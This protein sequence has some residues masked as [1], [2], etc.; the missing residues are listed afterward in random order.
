M[1]IDARLLPADQVVETDIC[2]VGTGAAGLS[3]AR[4]L[5]GQNF[6]VTLLESGG[7][8]KTDAALESLAEVQT[9]G[10]FVQVLASTRHRRFGGN[11]SYWEIN[12]PTGQVGLRHRPFDEVDFEQRDWI[13]YSGWPF[14][15]NHL[16]P[17]YERAQAAFGLKQFAYEGTDWEDAE[18]PCLPFV[19]DAITTRIFQFSPG[20]VFFEKYRETVCSAS[21]ITT[22]LHATVAELETDESAGT[23]KRARVACRNGKQF[24]VKARLFILAV[25]GIES[26]QLLLLSNQT[27]Q[28]GLGNAYDLV[29]RFFV[30]HPLV[31]GGLFIP[32]DPQIFNRTGLYDLRQVNGASIMGALGLTD[33]VMRREQLVNISFNLFPR[34]KRAFGSPA[35]SSLK[36]LLTLRAFKSGKALHHLQSALSG[37]DEIAD[38][39]YT[40]ATRQPL[41]LWCNF[42]TGGW[43]EQQKRREK[44]YQMFE[45]LHQTEQLPNPNNRVMLSEQRD[46]LGRRRVRMETTWRT[47][48]IEGVK[49]AQAVLAREIARSGLGRFEIA[50]R[51]DDLPALGSH[52]TAHHMGTTR[53]HV[54]PKQGVVDPNCKLHSVS[55]LFIASGAVF[56]TGGYAN[57]TLTIV[58]MSI[59]LADHVKKLMGQKLELTMGTK[60]PDMP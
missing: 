26:A 40:K 20:N 54:S 11:S 42:S 10:N 59:R 53:M 32:N 4:E 29:G 16:L 38:M 41:P 24:W 17:Y 60:S 23:V 36:Q 2:I 27:Q 34:P 58:A 28:Q 39:I 33:A 35:V 51:E 52:G 15:R 9:E 49:R 1:L 19:G 5:M 30:D 7:L 21:N 3:L 43:S 56:P 13:P 25:G 14:D 8:E 46:L 57:P 45:V 44:V 18:H 37:M 48:D 31:Y 6:Q 50:R 12:L 55:N 22:Y 47:A